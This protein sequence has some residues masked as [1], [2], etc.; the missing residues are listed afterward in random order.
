MNHSR[1]QC[2]SWHKRSCHWNE[3]DDVS[4]LLYV[5]IILVH[6]YAYPM[7]ED[8]LLKNW[9]YVWWILNFTILVLVIA[10]DTTMAK[11][12]SLAKHPL[13]LFNLTII[14]VLKKLRDNTWPYSFLRTDWSLNVSPL[15]Q[16]WGPLMCPQEC[17]HH[18]K[19]HIHFCEKTGLWMSPNNMNFGFL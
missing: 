14:A 16:F 4:E 2:T 8:I 18:I 17:P 6:T 12:D 11:M 1:L 5:S 7:W 13:A 9:G 19:I 3:V 15:Y 10:T